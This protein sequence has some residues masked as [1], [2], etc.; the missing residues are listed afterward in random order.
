MRPSPSTAAPNGRSA[1]SKPVSVPQGWAAVWDPSPP[2]QLPNAPR[3]PGHG[4]PGFSH[5]PWHCCLPTERDQLRPGSQRRGQDTGKDFFFCSQGAVSTHGC[6]FFWPG[7]YSWTSMTW[8]WPLLAEGFLW[9]KFYCLHCCKSSFMQMWQA[10]KPEDV[11]SHILTP[12][13]IPP[14]PNALKTAPQPRHRRQLQYSDPF[15]SSLSFSTQTELH[16]RQ[17]GSKVPEMEIILIPHRGAVQ[18][19]MSLFSSECKEQI[20]AAAGARRSTSDSSAHCLKGSPAAN[21][22]AKGCPRGWGKRINFKSCTHFNTYFPA[23]PVQMSCR[24]ASFTD[25]AELNLTLKSSSKYNPT[26]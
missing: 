1:W 20:Y 3:Q 10:I 5:G 14:Y 6:L 15:L 8:F 18:G 4:L 17:T 22:Y 16:L 12:R 11:S 13:H 2:C 7:G 25:W 19:W 24:D 23:S 26:T 9:A 21:P